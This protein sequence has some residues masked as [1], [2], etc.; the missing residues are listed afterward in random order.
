MDV[1][2]DAVIGID[3]SKD[4]LD[5]EVL[6]SGRHWQ[7]PNTEPALL[8]LANEI[9]VLRPVRIV[10]EATGGWE[11][12]AVSILADAGLP[13]I[14]VN[15]RQVRDFGRATGELAKTD[16]IDAHLLAL[17]AERVRPELRTLPDEAAQ[18]LS[19]LLARRRQVV[20]MLTAERQRRDRASKSLRKEIQQH[21]DWLNQHLA[22]ID[23]D[24]R[25][26][27]RASPLWREKED[28]LKSMPGVGDVLALTL[29]ADLPELG[30]LDRKQIAAL[31]G[32]APFNRDSGKL[33][34]RRSIWGGRASIRAVLYMAALVA[35][36]FNP[37]IRTFYQRL[38]LAGKPKKVALVACMRKLLTILNAMIKHHRPWSPVG[39]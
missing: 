25:D 5:I 31:V 35:T 23:R 8:A 13:V 9:Q 22:E 38:L 32:V 1:P 7:E 20:D 30:Q 6:P 39:A 14:V 36:R 29:V 10:L 37:T 26:S 18:A 15:P 12:Q 21:I 34:G 4:T 17:F 16:R 27:L 19:A 33:R 28:L 24:L 2:T 3:V 11:T